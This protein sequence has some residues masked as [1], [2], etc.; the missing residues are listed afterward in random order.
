V[1]AIAAFWTLQAAPNPAN[2]AFYSSQWAEVVYFLVQTGSTEEPNNPK[3][4]IGTPTYGLYRAQF[5]MVPNGTNVNSLFTV[6]NGYPA[7]PPSVVNHPNQVALS[8]QVFAGLSTTNPSGTNVLFNSPDDAAMGQRVISP[9]NL[10]PTNFKNLLATDGRFQVSDASGA[11]QSYAANLVLPNVLSFQIQVM[12]AYAT[13]F[14][15]LP[16]YLGQPAGSAY[17][18]FDTAQFN[19]TAFPNYPATARTALKGIQIT[20]RVF[21]SA[22]RQSRQMT[23]VQNM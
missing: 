20:L 10:T 11:T 21:D 14:G 4:T 5:V 23:I 9:A 15:D 19:A 13:N 18:L 2:Q 8:Q 22:S 7:V 12:P 6:A 17:A 16:T 3:S 1:P